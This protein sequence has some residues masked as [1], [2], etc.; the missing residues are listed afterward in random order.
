VDLRRLRDVKRLS[1]GPYTILW[2]LISKSD[3][4]ETTAS[5]RTGGPGQGLYAMPTAVV[6]SAWPVF[7]RGMAARAD[8]VEAEKER[9]RPLRRIN[10]AVVL[11]LFAG[12]V[13]VLAFFARFGAP[14]W[15]LFQWLWILTAAGYFFARFLARTY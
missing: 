9:G 4:S 13:G 15:Q 5:E 12:V 1:V 11:G 10:A 2:L 6:E 14:T 7:E 8:D 3:E